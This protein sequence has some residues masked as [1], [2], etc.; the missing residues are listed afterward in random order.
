MNR[1]FFLSL[2]LCVAIA[3]PAAPQDV[4]VSK[5][6]NL[7]PL[8][9]SFALVSAEVRETPEGTGIFLKLR[10]KKEVDTSDLYYHVGFFD[11]GKVVIQATP[12]K[13]QAEFP[14]QSGETVYAVCTYV[15]DPPG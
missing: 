7:G 4:N 6:I 5:T 13:F 8:A 14:L 1:V 11:K 15:G 2:L 3:R 9:D 10:A 12:L